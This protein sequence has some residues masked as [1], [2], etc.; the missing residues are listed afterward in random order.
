MLAHEFVR[1]SGRKIAAFYETREIRLASSSWKYGTNFRC[2]WS[3]TLAYLTGTP[4]QRGSIGIHRYQHIRWSIAARQ[5][6]RD[7]TERFSAEN[8]ESVTP[9]QYQRAFLSRSKLHGAKV[10]MKSPD[11]IWWPGT[12][13]TVRFVNEPF[14]PGC[15]MIP[16]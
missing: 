6:N 12:M 5:L 13:Y 4:N 7:C 14:E 9:K 8:L 11:D 3:A 15:T 1:G 16:A 10:W 2:F